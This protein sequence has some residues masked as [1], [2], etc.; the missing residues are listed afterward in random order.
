M[1]N[2]LPFSLLKRI[3]ISSFLTLFF[4]TLMYAQDS[5][6]ISFQGESIE[7][8]ENINSFEWEKMPASSKY[9]KGY[10]GWVQFYDTPDQNTQ[11]YFKSSKLQLIDYISNGTYSFYFPETTSI[12][13]L[14]SKGVRAIIPISGNLKMSKD[15][16]KGK[17]ESYAVQGNNVLVTMQLHKNVDASTVLKYLARLD[18]KI[19]QQYDHANL[20]ELSIPQDKLT[21]ISNKPFVKWMELIAPPAVP[22]D[23]RGRNLHRSSSLDTQTSAG[24]NYTGSGIGVMVRDDGVVGPHIDFQ[25]RIDNSAT[26]NTA[27]THGDGV[28][29]IFAGAGNLDPSRRGMAAG[30]DVYVVNYGGS[31]N[32]LETI[33]L[34]NSGQVQ[35]TNSSFGD[36]QNDGYTTRARTVDQQTTTIPSLLHVFSAGNSGTSDFGYGAGAGWGNIT[37]GHK[38]GK[39][40]IATANVFFEGTLVNSSSRG[41]AT[42]GRIKPDIAANGQNQISTNPNN[43][44]Q[45]FGGTSGAAPGIA[46]VSAQLYEAYGNLNSG[47]LPESALI[48]A[49]LLNTANDAGNI[50]PDFKFGWG[51]I[52]GLRAGKLIED[53]RYLKSTVS[54]SNANNHTINV[55]AGTTQV[56]FMVYWSDPAAAAGATTALINDLDLVV[57][58]PSST[59]HLPWILDPTPNAAN[60]DT[61][62]ING[63]DRL[64]NMEQVLL[65]N[66]AAG[67]YDINVTGFNV[68]VGPQEYYVVYEVITEELTLTYPNGGESF[69]PGEVESLHWDAINT[70]SNFVLEYSTDAGTSWNSIATLPSLATNYAW[71]V[72]ASVTGQALVRITSGSFTDTSDAAFSIASLPSNLVFSQVCPTEATLT[73][74][75]VANAESYDV[76]LLGNKY[77]TVVANSTTSSITIP[78]PDYRISNWAA[79]VAKNDTEGWKSRRTIAI[80][81]SGGLLNCVIN[82]DISVLS[83]QNT[84][85]E[86]LEIGCA[87]ASDTLI[88]VTLENLGVNPQSNF[89][90]SYQLDSNTAVQ[91]TYSGTLNAGQQVVYTFTTALVIPSNGNYDLTVTSNLVGDQNPFNDSVALNFEADVDGVPE[92]VC[93]NATV[94]LDQTGN[95]S[96]TALDVVDNID[97]IG[98]TQQ[99]ISHA[100]IAITGTTVSLGDD[101]G[102]VA[103]PVGFDFD[104]YSSS[105]SQFHIASNGF[106]SFTGNGMTDAA[107]WTPASLPNTNVPNGMIA[108]VWDDLSP[109]ISG[110]IRYEMIGTAPNRKLVV[111]YEAVPLYNSAATVTAQLQ[112]HEGRNIIEIHTTNAANDGG[113]RTQG[114]EDATG[115]LAVAATGKNLTS[116][117]ATNEAVRFTPIQGQLPD[118]CGNPVTLSL[119]ASTFTLA[120]V[121]DNTVTVTADDGNGGVSTCQA[122]VTVTRDPINFIWESG[123][124]ISLDPSG[125]S[126]NTD[127]IEIRSPGASLTAS[128]TVGDLSILSG[129]TLDLGNNELA[130][131]GNLNA[132]G[133]LNAMNAT[134]LFN[135]VVD[136]QITGD[137]QIGDLV[138]DNN[139]TNGVALLSNGTVLNRLDLVNGVLNTT[140]GS[141]T[142]H[143]DGSNTAMVDQVVSGSVTGEVT[144]ESYIPG[145]RA[146]RL[147]SSAVTTSTPINTNWQ[148][149][150]HNTTTTVNV[151]SVL[152]YGTHIT[153]STTGANGFDASSTGNA[154]MFSYDNIGQSWGAVLNTD[155]DH[156]LAGKPYRLIVRGSRAID[157]NSP[158]A[159]IIP[160]ATTLRAKGTLQTGDV[161]F[162][163]IGGVAGEFNFIGNPYQ[164]SVNMN[165]VM[166][167]STNINA[168][169]YYVWDPQLGA[170]GAY[171]TIILPAGTNTSMSAANQYLQPGQAAFLETLANGS[172][173]VRFQETHKVVGQNTATFSTPVNN[174]SIVGQL[175]RSEN[176]VVAQKVQD[177]FGIFF[178]SN[179]NSGI[180][181]F[182]AAK[183]YNQDETIGVQKGPEVL[184]IE[185]RP[186]PVT[187]EIISLSHLSYRSTNY[188]YKIEINNVM[189]KQVFLEDSFLNTSTLLNDGINRYDFSVDA[190]NNS[191][192]ANRFSLKIEDQTLG[193]E[194]LQS[195]VVLSLIPN[196]VVTDVVELVVDGATMSHG[197]TAIIYNLAGQRLWEYKIDFSNNRAQLSGLSKL[198]AGAYFLKLESDY[199]S[200]TIKLIKK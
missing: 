103:L 33:N 200:Q 60:L 11:D 159:A 173:Q 13:L 84:N 42:D 20:V 172:G 7:V 23:T 10:Y 153:G 54:Q 8:L 182:D 191:I 186:L 79:I 166:T 91:E 99:P 162:S 26:T 180:D 109:N 32:D 185:R 137:F 63:V 183:L 165:A 98:Y 16:K 139:S 46:G 59:A 115:S 75:P 112:L 145:K 125:I 108:V 127:T 100:P 168:N 14:K 90:V 80:N 123:S 188:Q 51:I 181:A 142:L 3:L 88:A 86:F 58:D 1:V 49:T 31:F 113:N 197:A 152:G 85:Q 110:T 96:I 187:D 74:N 41:P 35:I 82:Q 141:L 147:L 64:N 126:I 66:P 148:E 192:A 83:I 105:Y 150:G 76:Y 24:R 5:Y 174:S 170:R 93:K 36:G 158:I 69:A 40:V 196:P 9:N 122:I 111:N 144:V 71:S 116:W 154:S 15:L 155:T 30:S 73:W 6:S 134:L 151:N 179:A 19:L 29:G 52:N 2:S 198:A 132:A 77:M 17:Y 94:M 190:N 34:L 53:G 78:I 138:I 18:I 27:G 193:L 38:Q 44:Y 140:A 62:A 28:A 67:S 81:H 56:R 117:T 97:I 57:T 37:G 101:N 194:D 121:G 129:G 149:G 146:F 160:D 22:E 107:S 43:T 161:P 92:L 65:N 120:D 95:A 50:G 143:S 177:S 12:A 189:G 119:S 199:F 45:T 176:A 48:K 195:G 61:P 89:I 68:P 175:F 156:L 4:S 25:G 164:A 131:S 171:T 55:P 21:E 184:A 118:N 157:L 47:A 124:W 135:G 87:G 72:P 130:L 102:T 169:F 133:T 163:N 167:A 178:D 136:Q 128:S 104:F 39:N 114:L 70:T 106:V